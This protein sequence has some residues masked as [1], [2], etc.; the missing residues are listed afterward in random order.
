MVNNKHLRAKPKIKLHRKH[1]LHSL[2]HSRI[3]HPNLVNRMHRP[4][5]G[6]G[7]IEKEEA[8]D[9]GT[10]PGMDRIRMEELKAKRHDQRREPVE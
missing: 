1:S 8:G 4:A 5:R 9:K 6:E 7:G 2:N 10:L 3:Q